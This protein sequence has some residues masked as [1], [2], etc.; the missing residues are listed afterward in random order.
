[1]RILTSC[2]LTFLSNLS[3]DWQRLYRWELARLQRDEDAVAEPN[4][5]YR[6][7]PE[8]FPCFDSQ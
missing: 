1:M 8:D 3:R 7:Q 5:S 2:E 6:K 4:N